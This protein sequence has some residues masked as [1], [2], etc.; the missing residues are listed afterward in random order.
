MAK[1]TAVQ[2]AQ[3]FI[4]KSIMLYRANKGDLLS[5]LKLQKLLYYAQGSY[6][7]LTGEKLF[8][9]KILAWEHGPVIENIY[10]KYRQDFAIDKYKDVVIDRNTSNILDMVYNI[11]GQYSAWKLRDMTHNETPWQTTL[12]NEEIDCNKIKE[13]FKKH[14]VK[15]D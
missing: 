10:K 4:N 13:Y 7:A 15:E 1:Y 12:L 11:F 6:L 5:N 2:I 3:W 9:D 14:Y 8:N